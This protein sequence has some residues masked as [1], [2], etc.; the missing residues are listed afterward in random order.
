MIININNYIRVDLLGIFKTTR[1]RTTMR[2]RMLDE[3]QDNTVMYEADGEFFLEALHL[4]AAEVSSRTGALKDPDDSGLDA[5]TDAVMKD[6]KVA[7]KEM[8]QD[9]EEGTEYT[10]KEIFVQYNLPNTGKE[11]KSTALQALIHEAL[12]R[13]ILVQW[14]TELGLYEESQVHDQFYEKALSQYNGRSTRFQHKE[15]K[16]VGL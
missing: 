5:L 12:S 3:T 1:R 6:G 15:R 14:Y 9:H 7:L 2:S 4:A 13:H 11:F 16:Y 8:G 10:K